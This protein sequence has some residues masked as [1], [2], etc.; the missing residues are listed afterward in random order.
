MLAVPHSKGRNIRPTRGA[1]DRIR[2]SS[3]AQRFHLAHVV[4]ESASVAQGTDNVVI[5]SL[6]IAHALLLSSY[7]SDHGRWLKTQLVS[8]GSVHWAHELVDGRDGREHDAFATSAS[9]SRGACKHVELATNLS[10]TVA[11]GLTFTKWTRCRGD[12]PLGTTQGT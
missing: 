12:R 7:C 5:L 2:S 9:G 4:S 6:S 10:V 1:M 8:A 3:R 11:R